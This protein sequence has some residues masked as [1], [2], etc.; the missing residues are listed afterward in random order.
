MD[1][2]GIIEYAK[3]QVRKYILGDTEQT[4]KEILLNHLIDSIELRDDTVH[5]KT[6]KNILL[7]N[8]GHVFT[9]NSGMN[10]IKAKQIHLNPKINFDDN[11]FDELKLR[12]DEA[13]RLEMV[14]FKKEQERIQKEHRNCEH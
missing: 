10:V 6:T 1:R 8:N 14:E 4:K 3:R 11:N 12:L 2:V 13:R 7:E 9:I 5:I